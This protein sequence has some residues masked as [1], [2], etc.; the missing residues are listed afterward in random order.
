MEPAPPLRVLFIGNSLTFFRE[1]RE[2]EAYLLHDL[3]GLLVRMASGRL[4]AE[5]SARS[6]AGLKEHWDEG[7]LGGRLAGARWDAVVLQDSS[8]GPVDDPAAMRAQGLNLDR[9]IRGAGCRTILFETW[10]ARGGEGAEQIASAYAGLG[11][12]LGAVVVPVG[13]AWRRVASSSPE[14]DLYAPDGVHAGPLG[15]YLAACVFYG[16]LL[17]EDPA[18]RPG[19]GLAADAE[20]LAPFADC[21]KKLW[22]G[23]GAGVLSPGSLEL[24]QSAAWRCVRELHPALR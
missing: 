18:G 12:E 4:A 8:R 6:G 20:A 22:G 2:G 14:I 23:P 16:A 24:L 7:R 10:P 1:E 15:T 11:A 9:A 13:T 5:A 21:Q 19:R 3:P 17:G